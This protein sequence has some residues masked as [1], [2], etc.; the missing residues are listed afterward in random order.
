MKLDP[1]KFES[2]EFADPARYWKE[3]NYLS[4]KHDVHVSTIKI[5]D[6]TFGYQPVVFIKGQYFG[7]L[8]DVFYAE[9]EKGISEEEFFA[10]IDHYEEYKKTNVDS[11]KLRNH[12]VWLATKKAMNKLD[13][14]E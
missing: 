11:E 9:M 3:I 14:K 12:S 6:I 13:N 7:Y 1:K 2:Q 4:K 5:D 8:N 10:D